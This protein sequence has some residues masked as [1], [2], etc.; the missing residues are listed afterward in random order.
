M[1]RHLPPLGALRAFESAMRHGRLADAA[2]EL[3]VT[4]SAVSH[5]IRGLEADLGIKLVRR[6]G[7]RLVPTAA[8]EAML[9]GLR[10]GFTRIGEAVATVRELEREGPVTLSVLQ[11][12]AL[13]WLVPRLPGFERRYPASE[14]RLAIGGRPVDFAREDVDL[15]VRHGDG[16]WPGLR[17]DLLF[18]DA[19]LP[20]ASPILLSREPPLLA[21]EHLARHT[22]LASAARPDAWPSWLASVGLPGLAGARTQ[23][24]ESTNLALQAAA[25]GLGVAIAGRR[26]VRSLVEA[27]WLVVPFRQSCGDPKAYWVTCPEEWAG[28]PRIR[29]VRE[30]LLEEARAEED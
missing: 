7:R 25:R 24:F 22:L 17:S 6:E 11:T 21:P 10:E 9:P 3:H 29:R 14:V 12:F 1:S 30:W 4:A 16:A 23:T 8:G 18:R 15:A 19:L 28:L 20:V 2:E 13:H 5:Q 26:L 27:R